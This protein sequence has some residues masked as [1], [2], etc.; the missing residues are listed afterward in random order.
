MNLR[1]GTPCN[2]HPSSALYGLGFSADYVVYH[3]L[4]LTTKEYMRCVTI[5]DPEWLADMGPM[6]FSIKVFF[7]SLFLS[8]IHTVFSNFPSLSLSS[9]S[10][11]LYN[12]RVINYLQMV[13]F[14]NRI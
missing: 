13:Y 8:Y 3:E 12:L 1:T 5:V 6:F 4:V 7:L 10:L 2:L 11:S 14:R 9:L